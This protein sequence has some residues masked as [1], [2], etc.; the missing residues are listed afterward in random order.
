MVDSAVYLGADRTEAKDQMLEAL[1][2]EL[3]LAE[4]SITREAKRNKTAINNH[5]S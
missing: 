3:K 5:V 2:L 1:K 4:I